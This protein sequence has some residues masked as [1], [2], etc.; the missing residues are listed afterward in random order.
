MFVLPG[1]T[2]Q[3]M[4]G[5]PALGKPVPGIASALACVLMEMRPHR[6]RHVLSLAEHCP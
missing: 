3:K 5:G 6:K 1:K 2:C 4:I